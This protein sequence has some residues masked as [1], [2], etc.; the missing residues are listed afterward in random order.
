M[1]SGNISVHRQRKPIAR[2][3]WN[4]K[5]PQ[6]SRGARQINDLESLGLFQIVEPDQYTAVA[7]L[8]KAPQQVPKI[9][10]SPPIQTSARRHFSATFL[11]RTS[12]I[13]DDRCGKC[14]RHI[15]H[16]R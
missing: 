6:A 2:V 16:P 14:L 9:V 11:A 4:G 12:Y 5:E 15:G 13:R 1:T 10:S 7:M 8:P 3:G